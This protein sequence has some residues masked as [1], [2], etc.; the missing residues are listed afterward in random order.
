VSAG[1]LTVA[2]QRVETL[3]ERAGGRLGAVSDTP[4]LD[5]ELLLGHVLGTGRAAL[6]ARG[7]QEVGPRA[8][9]AFEELLQRRAA[10]EP[11]AYLTGRRAFW[12]LDLAVGPGVLV[13]RPETE[14]LVEAAVARLG[15]Q[16]GPAVLDLGTGSGAIALAIASEL[17]TAAVTGVDASPA[18]LETARR[19]AQDYGLGR[20]RFLRSDWYGACSGQRFDAV[21]SNP[22]YLA[23][24][25]PHL[26]A[27]S[28]EPLAALVAG[29]T[30]LEAL[31]RI[32][33]GAPAHLLPGGALLLE[34]GA[35]QGPEVRAAC[36]AAGLENI[37]TLRD[38]AGHERVTVARA[39]AP[40]AAAR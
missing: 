3:L 16:P 23:A 29:P 21:V 31:E 27:L 39:P 38:L 24:S 7:E 19:N 37:E 4:R 22:P 17:P 2:L 9:A 1:P 32:I 26:P 11:V 30:G 36:A 15:N 28:Q 18:A 35:G 34:H 6:R 25:D 10:G 5:A 14:L 13:P 33:S 20:V 12:T 8:L 40:P